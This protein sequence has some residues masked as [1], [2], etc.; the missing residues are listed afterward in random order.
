MSIFYLVIAIL[1]G[2]AGSTMLKLNVMAGGKGVIF[3]II[4]SYG[5]SFYLLSLALLSL[6]LSFAYAT[7][8]GLGTALT[9]IIGVL[10]FKEKINMITVIGIILLVTGIILMRI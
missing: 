6:P 3:G 10:L 9:A 2:V 4:A 1:L 8:S 7:W 5:L